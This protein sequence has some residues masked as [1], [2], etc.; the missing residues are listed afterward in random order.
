MTEL[1]DREQV[2]QILDDTKNG[3]LK[4]GRL[5]TFGPLVMVLNRIK[6]LPVMNSPERCPYCGAELE[7]RK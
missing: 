7:D 1:I 5:D 6:K 3:L 4:A 2:L